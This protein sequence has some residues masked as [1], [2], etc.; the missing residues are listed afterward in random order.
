[1]IYEIAGLRVEIANQHAYTTKF[2]QAYLSKN[3]DLPADLTAIV[4]EAE[5]QEEREASAG[6]SDGY[7]ENICLY[8]SICRQIPAKNR[9]LL[10]ASILERN[11]KAYAFLG[12]SGTGKSTH[13]KLWLRYVENTCVLNGDKPILEYIDGKLY[14]HGTPWQGKE[15]WGYNGRAE[16]CGLCFLEQAKVNEIS[17]M[18]LSETSSRVFTQVLLPQDEENVVAT[19]DLLDKLVANVPAYLLKCDIS[20]EA[21]KLSFEQLTGEIYGPTMKSED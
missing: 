5:M 7:I 6:F 14:A 17:K 1:M 18:S 8:R 9:F 15:N 13:T 21:V 20:E 10:H 2:C 12:R 4:T 19:L 3:Q 11:G 16:L